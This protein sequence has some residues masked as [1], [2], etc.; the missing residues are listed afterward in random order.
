MVFALENL[1]NPKSKNLKYLT[2]GFFYQMPIDLT[3]NE[4]S[5]VTSST[6]TDSNVVRSGTINIPAA[7]GFGLANRFGDRVN[8][9][10]DAYFQQWSDYSDFGVTPSNFT[11]SSRFG[12]GFELL[13]SPDRDRS[14]FEKLTYRAGGFYEKAYYLVNSEEINTLGFSLGVGIPISDFNSIDLSFNYSMR[15]KEENG[16]IKDRLFMIHAGVN[17]GELWFLRPDEDF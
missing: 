17:F 9:A 8:V 10:V 14:F 16:L 11:N 12:A 6:G 7:Y 5:I 13:P 3:A 4:E 1:V 2:V 15:G